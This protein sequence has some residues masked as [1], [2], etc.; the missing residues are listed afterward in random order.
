MDQRSVFEKKP[1]NVVVYIGK[2]IFEKYDNDVDNIE[3]DDDFMKKCDGVCTFFGIT[4]DGQDYNFLY[5][6]IKINE[7]FDIDNPEKVIYPE[8]KGKTVIYEIDSREYYVHTYTQDF[9]SYGDDETDL[10][11]LRM[12]SSEDLIDF[13][14]GDHDSELIE[15]D[16]LRAEIKIE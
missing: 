14:S 4:L 5:N 15:S 7:E 9:I 13:Y 3:Y 11:F 10:E 6:L 16:N 12:C 2:S 8:R 1:K